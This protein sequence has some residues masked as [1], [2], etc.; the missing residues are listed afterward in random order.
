MIKSLTCKL[1]LMI[2]KLLSIIALGLL[3]SGNANSA[4]MI[5]IQ[6]YIKNNSGYLNDTTTK[7]YVLKRCAASYLYYAGITKDNF[8]KK[9][10]LIANDYKKV[11]IFTGDILID[12]M[13]W[14][15]EV[16]AMSL[17]TDIGNMWKYYEKDGNDSFARTGDYIVGNYI[18]EDI[19]FCKEVVKNIK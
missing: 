4:S 7:T 3:L 15:A 14:T 13:Q 6:K 5:S 9:S 17:N 18:G 19:L 16:T 2:K 8:P 10:Q 11:L 1:K 12:E